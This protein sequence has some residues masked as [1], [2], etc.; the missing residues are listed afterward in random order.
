MNEGTEQTSA[1]V[2]Q[3]VVERPITDNSTAGEKQDTATTAE[4][5]ELYKDLGIDAP[6]P[7]GKTRDDLSPLLF[8][9]KTLKQTQIKI[10]SL[11]GKKKYKARVSKK[12]HLLQIKM[13]IQEMILTRRARKSGRLQEKYQANQMKLTKEFAR[14]NPSLKKILSQEAKMTLESEMTQLASDQAKAAQKS[15]SASKS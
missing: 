1:A 3:S 10:P 5:S 11:D 14:I 9:I 7:T 8:E 2:E 4:V 12:M 15:K 13:A 6:V